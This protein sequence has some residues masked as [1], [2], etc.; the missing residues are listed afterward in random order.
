MKNFFIGSLGFVCVI[1]LSNPTFGL[2][3][4]LPDTIPFM[5]NLD[6][7]S[8]TIIL[9]AVLNHFGVDIKGFL[10]MKDKDKK[11]DK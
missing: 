1:Y 2:L 5:G 10:G 11:Q 7:A 4:I 8:A 6:E 3:E 9:L